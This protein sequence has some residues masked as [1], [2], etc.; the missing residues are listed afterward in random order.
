MSV[1]IEEINAEVESNQHHEGGGE[2]EARPT[3]NQQKQSVLD[4]LELTQERKARLVID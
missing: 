1:I 3:E 2:G 4:L